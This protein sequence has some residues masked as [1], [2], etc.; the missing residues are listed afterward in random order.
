MSTPP[1]TS[2]SVTTQ[3]I[4]PYTRAL[5]DLV[6]LTSHESQELVNDNL[7]TM[8]EWAARF[9]ACRLRYK[10]IVKIYEESRIAISEQ[11]LKRAQDALQTG[12][13]F[14]LSRSEVSWEGEWVD[15]RWKQAAQQRLEIEEQKRKEEDRRRVE[16]AHMHAWAIYNLEN[17]DLEYDYSTDLEDDNSQDG[18]AVKSRSSTSPSSS[19]GGTSLERA[20]KIVDTSVKESPSQNQSISNNSISQSKDTV[21]TTTISNEALEV[22]IIGNAD[23]SDPSM[24]MEKRKSLTCDYDE[25]DDVSDRKRP[26]IDNDDEAQDGCKIAGPKV[27]FAPSTPVAHP[28][29]PFDYRGLSEEAQLA[30]KFRHL[31][32][33]SRDQDQDIISVLKYHF[34]PGSSIQATE[35]WVKEVSQTLPP[36]THC[37]K[38]GRV[39]VWS[40]D[41]A[42]CDRCW[43]ARKCSFGD[44]FRWHRA[45]SQLPRHDPK[46]IRKK[47]EEIAS[48]S[49]A[50]ASSD[51]FWYE[52]SDL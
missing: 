3:T 20:S 50:F 43:H 8:V 44:T 38:V 18:S 6:Q 40:S 34:T 33:L 37:Y 2:I 51:P 22:R 17:K 15:P 13:L 9:A 26:R 41:R 10:H 27:Y 1:K 4:D 23:V 12:D 16:E 39:C 42:S 47:M 24:A 21:P 11:N 49:S 5:V 19:L 30:L 28:L 29:L 32:P 45:C 25:N 35:A 52:E 14:V 46:E 36:C 7:I 31:N 48:Q